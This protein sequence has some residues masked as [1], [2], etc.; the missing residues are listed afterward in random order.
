MTWHGHPDF[1]VCVREKCDIHKHRRH[2]GQ[3]HCESCLDEQNEGY[4]GVNDFTFLSSSTG[5]DRCCCRDNRIG[6]EFRGGKLRKRAAD[7]MEGALG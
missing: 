5:D 1:L 7:A 6:R 4:S 3:G 2:A